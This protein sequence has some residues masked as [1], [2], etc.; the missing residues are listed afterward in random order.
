MPKQIDEEAQIARIVH[1]TGTVLATQGIDGL[2]L[3]AVAR[4][5]GCTTGLL[6]H[7]FASKADLVQAALTHTAVA[8][9]ARVTQ[10]L[11]ASP[12]DVLGAI[13][14]FLPLDEQRRAESRIWLSFMA[15]A[16]STP[17]LM[18]DHQQR[19][20]RFRQEII[21]HLQ[22][23]GFRGANP[24]EVADRII[25][26]VDGIC[27]GATLDPAYWTPQRQRAVLAANVV[28]VIATTRRTEKKATHSPRKQVATPRR[29]VGEGHRS[30]RPR[31]ANAPKERT[32][33]RR[34][35]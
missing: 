13:A 16:M 21:A 12:P 33:R 24:A 5:A 32:P 27:A 7:W 28:D 9:S 17:A 18:R 14:E 8:Q 29:D 34:F 31:A 11:A 25:A 20:A 2:S 3:R 23:R 22:D 1:A 10:R 26:L 4:E 6:M 30:V 19:Y 15:L 35:T